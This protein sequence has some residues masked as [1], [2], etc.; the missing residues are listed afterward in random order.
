MEHFSEQVWADYVRG[1]G[2]PN[3]SREVEA[4]LANG[5][6]DCTRVCGMW[7]KV[8]SIAANEA[9]FAPPDGVVRVVKQALAA[10]QAVEPSPWTL[11]RLVFDS[12]NQP[13]T[14]GVRSGAS[15]ARQLMFDA[16]GTIVDLVLDTRPQ[17]QMISLVGQVVDKHGAKV[18]PRQVRVVLWTETSQPVAEVSANEFGEFQLEFAAQ[19]RLRLSVEIVGYKH[20]SIPPLNLTSNVTRAVTEDRRSGY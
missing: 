15:D 14:A 11:A 9:S 17:S 18:A 20:I 12:L 8:Y 6:P 10:R 3:T 19:D 2:Q 5:C 13:L 4:H 1:I 7:K 16:E